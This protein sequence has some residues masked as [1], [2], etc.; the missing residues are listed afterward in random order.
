M[1]IPTNEGNP[2]NRYH[3]EQIKRH[4]DLSAQ[5][6]MNAGLGDIAG[7]V[8][9]HHEHF[10]GTGYP[11]GLQGHDIPIG[12]RIVL[13]CEAFDV[14]TTD[15]PYRQAMSLGDAVTEL[16]RGAGSRFDPEVVSALITLIQEG[17]VRPEGGQVPGAIDRRVA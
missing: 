4:P 14:M 2:L 12:S 5:I 11:L 15:R 8:R 17:D 13:V 7:W 6:V 10:D 3:L 16:T 9:H 1:E